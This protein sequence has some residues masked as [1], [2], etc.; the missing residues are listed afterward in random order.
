MAERLTEADAL[1]ALRDVRDNNGT[2]WRC[3][4]GLAATILWDD[5]NRRGWVE[6]NEITPAGRRA[7][8][9]GGDDAS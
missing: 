4:S 5:L 7:L 3:D 6:G 8:Q 2:M 9:S 1:A